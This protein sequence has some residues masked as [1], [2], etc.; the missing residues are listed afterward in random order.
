MGQWMARTLDH[1]IQLNIVLAVFNL[2]PIPPLD[3]WRVL[4]GL[5]DARTAYSLRQYEQYGFIV[6]LLIVVAGRDVLG[7]LIGGVL[8]FLL[9]T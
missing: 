8:R 5:V 4:L 7:G 2:L 3:G 9:G 6:L 1:S